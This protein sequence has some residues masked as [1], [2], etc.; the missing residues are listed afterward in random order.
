[1]KIYYW[2]DAIV[3]SNTLF[4]DSSYHYPVLLDFQ[5]TPNLSNFQFDSNQYYWSTPSPSYQS[6]PGVGWENNTLD[7][8]DPLQHGTYLLSAWQGVGQE[9]HAAVQHF[10][11]Y[12]DSSFDLS[13]NKVF[14]L[15]NVYDPKRANLLVYNWNMLNNVDVDVSGILNAGDHYELHNVLNYFNDV[16][17]GTYLGGMLSVPMT[18]HSVAFPLGY[19]LLLGESTFPG[20]G[21]FILL[22]TSTGSVLPV[23]FTSFTASS[24]NKQVLLQWTTEQ[25]QNVNQY[26]VERSVNGQDFTP[27]AT[28]AA[29]GNPGATNH[30][31][32]NDGA[33]FKP[34]S[35][36][37]IREVE[38][39]NQHTYSS[40]QKVMFKQ[41]L[42]YSI[43]PNPATDVLQ[44]NLNLPLHTDR[45]ELLL[46]DASGMLLL[47]RQQAVSQQ[48]LIIPLDI[49]K[50]PKGNYF[51]TI[52]TPAETVTT[53]F[54]KQ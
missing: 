29:S 10:P 32:Y 8:S 1:V 15:P 3:K 28:V 4:A 25:E 24:V 54:L 44:V 6:E 43:K 16:V 52:K 33:P 12:D 13:G 31:Q 9:M 23:H 39:S 18:G 36:Y 20:F 34:V 21:S 45:V 19:P 51:L 50:F 48:E 2:N 37:R 49:S 35:Y 27:I 11:Y 5:G 14:L 30:Y 53:Q 47:S 46:R 42:V 22:N 26:I 17:S 38:T 40:I 7:A 41:G